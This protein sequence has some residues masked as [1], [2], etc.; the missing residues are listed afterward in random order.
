VVTGKFT[1]SSIA[2]REYVSVVY[3]V[4][5]FGVLFQHYPTCALA[6][7][8]DIPKAYQHVMELPWTVCVF[9]CLFSDTIQ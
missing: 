9:L 1:A 6:A 7:T 5:K 2:D 4:L 3:P 8:R